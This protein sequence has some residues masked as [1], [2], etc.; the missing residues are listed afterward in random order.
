MRGRV[1]TGMI[2]AA[3][4]LLAARPAPAQDRAYVFTKLPLTDP[5]NSSE[6]VVLSP[7]DTILVEVRIHRGDSLWKF[8]R[9]AL[10]HPARYA[11]LLAYN[12]S[13]RNPNRIIAGRTIWVP[14][15]ILRDRW[16]SLK[17]GR[18]RWVVR[19]PEESHARPGETSKPHA[20]AF[21]PLSPPPTAAKAEP[22]ADDSNGSAAL[23]RE[24]EGLFRRARYDEAARRLESLLDTTRDAGVRARAEFLLAECYRMQGGG[25]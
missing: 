6:E 16:K 13:I 17:A 4:L 8:A 5:A 12:P 23:L 2:G 15:G 11:Q 14:D 3:A 24:S 21:P 10:K 1:I 18:T 25:K 20:S 9:R 7:G 22:V 19:L